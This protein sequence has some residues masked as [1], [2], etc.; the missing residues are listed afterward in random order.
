[1]RTLIVSDLHLGQRPG[2]DVLRRPEPRERLLAA[3]DGVDRLVLLGDVVELASKLAARSPMEVAKPVLRAIGERVGSGG[4]IVLVPG[5]H[6]AV[7]ARAWVRERGG[8]LGIADEMPADA[9]P[10]SAAI[11]ELLAPARVRV[12]HPG[13][14]L[15]DRVWATHGHYLDRHLVP[16]STFGLPRW[17]PG[18]PPAAGRPAD[19]ERARRRE[20]VRE[21]ESLLAQLRE[22]PLALVLEHLA[23]LTR[24]ATGLLR[25]A[26]LTPLTARLIDLQMRRAA[27]PAMARVAQ[28]LG[29][30]A[31]WI[32]FGHVHRVGPDAG[33]EWRLQAGGPRLLNTGSWLYEPLLLDHVS[34]PHPYWPGGAVLLQDGADPQV[35]RLLDDF[36][37]LELSGARRR[38]R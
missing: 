22:R 11:A 36:S 1:V 27:L 29:V 5:N 28:T 31:D 10:A 3:L 13:V 20:R 24:Y 14:W 17:R 26:H 33:E 19:Y 7:I 30:E 21:S 2:H 38:E 4:E 16:E 25:A 9:T 8:A 12:S 18:H 35:L 32:V 37:G 6:D 15:G 23:E 34:P